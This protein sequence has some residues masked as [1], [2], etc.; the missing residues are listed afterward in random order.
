MPRVMD[1][2]EKRNKAAELYTEARELELRRDYAGARKC[3]EQ[4]L[5]LHEDEK[6]RAAYLKLLATIGPM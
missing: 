2:A 3:Y 6:V 5:A 1:T 4:S